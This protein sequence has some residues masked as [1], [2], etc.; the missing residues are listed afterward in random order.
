MRSS[1]IH[2]VDLVVS[3]IERALDFYGD[4]LG[5]IGW[6]PPFTAAG[7]RGETIHY[8]RGPGSTLGLRTAPGGPTGLPVDRYRVGLHHVC[9]EAPSAELLEA[10]AERVRHH[11]CRI[12]D[13]PRE[14]PEYGRGYLVMFARDPDGLKLEISFD[15]RERGVPDEVSR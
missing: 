4:V 10:A 5:A 11:G 12:T 13:G 2:H 6:E 7:E 9:F 8:L 15:G 1:G 3:D 14:M